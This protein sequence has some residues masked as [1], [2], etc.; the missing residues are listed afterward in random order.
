MSEIK[1]AVLYGGVSA[2]HDVSVKSAESV[3]ANIDEERFEIIAVEISKSGEFDIEKIQSAD[4]AFP[5]LHGRGGEDGSIQG[6]CEVLHKPYVGSGIE[7]SV[8]ALDKIA[9]KQIWQN[10]NFPVPSFQFFTRKQWLENPIVIMQKIKPPVF[11][12]PA[13]TGSSIGIYKVK[14]KPQLKQA[15]V[16]VLKCDNHIIIEEALPNIREIEVAIL[17]NDDLIISPPGEIIPADEFYS[18]KAKYELD[19]KLIV[20]AELSQDKIREIRT[21][22][23]K[24]YQVLGCSGMARVDFFLKKPEGKIYLNEINTIPGFTSISMYPKLMEAAGIKYR[25]LLTKLIELGLENA[26]NRRL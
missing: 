9:S 22:A 4:I 13:N 25:K 15:I 24:A 20:P 8:L 1:V 14:G 2:E 21:L 19:S 26:K 3:M 16:Q 7:A 17:G 18:Y 11:V 12:K 10:L 23:E 6:F 5:I